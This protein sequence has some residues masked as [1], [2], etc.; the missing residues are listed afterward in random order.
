MRAIGFMVGPLIGGLLAAA[1]GI[2]PAL[3][4]DATTFLLIGGVLAPCRSDVA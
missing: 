4:A 3:L 2:R 1:A